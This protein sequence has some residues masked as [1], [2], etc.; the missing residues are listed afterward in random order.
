[1]IRS[2]V[3]CLV[4]VELRGLEPLTPCL[5]N[6]HRVSC[7]VCGLGG[8]P[9]LVCSRPPISGLVGVSC[10]CHRWVASSSRTV[11]TVEWLTSWPSS[12]GKW[13]LLRTASARACCRTWLLYG[14]AVWLSSVSLGHPQSTFRQGRL[15]RTQV[16]LTNIENVRL[17]TDTSS[18]CG[19]GMACRP[20]EDAISFAHVAGRDRP[21]F[22]RFGHDRKDSHHQLIR[23]DLQTH[24]LLAFNHVDLPKQ[25]LS[26]RSRRQRWAPL[27]GQNAAI[28]GRPARLAGRSFSVKTQLTVVPQAP[29]VGSHGER[30][31]FRFVTDHLPGP[32]RLARPR[33]E[34]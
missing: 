5:Q 2:G 21:A 15:E 24:R 31:R 30:R 25:C 1:V 27:C 11:G 28:R 8:Q 3:F 34:L 18:N 22:S 26:L 12:F 6:P 32:A 14:L 9:L 17:T 29:G 20:V 19:G 16:T 33:A 7:M 10:G 23:R 13:R 4:G